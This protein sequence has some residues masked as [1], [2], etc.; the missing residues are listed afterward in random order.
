MEK[1]DQNKIALAFYARQNRQIIAVATALFLVLFAAVAY[2]RPDIFGEISKAA[3]F[4]AQTV[5]I[6]AF[7]AFTF[8]NWRCPACGK[9]LGSDLFRRG[10]RHCGVRLS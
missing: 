4:G 8:F 6:A 7:V 5:V 10:C 1:K 9:Y 3:L 2:K